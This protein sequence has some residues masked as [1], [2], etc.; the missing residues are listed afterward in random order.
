MRRY[1]ILITTF[2]QLAVYAQDYCKMVK[3]EVSN[4]TTFTYTSPFDSAGVTPVKVT[5]IFS[6]D[7]DQPF[8][9]FMIQFQLVTDLQEFYAKNPHGEGENDSKIFTVEFDDKSKI[10][11][12]D[13]AFSFDPLNENQTL[14]RGCTLSL[15]GADLTALS[16]KLITRFIMS[17][18]ARNLTPDTAQ[19][20]KAYI[21]CIKATHK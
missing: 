13:P 21:N 8:D 5:R 17:G 10:E 16:T 7:A 18:Y 3:K 15:E 9:N 14:I 11:S 19:A 20:Y 12:K 2:C 6:T 4:E 1:L